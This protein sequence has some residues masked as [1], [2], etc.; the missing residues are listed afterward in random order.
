MGLPSRFVAFGAPNA[1]SGLANANGAPQPNVLEHHQAIHSRAVAAPVPHPGLQLPKRAP[2]AGRA[3]EPSGTHDAR[4]IELPPHCPRANTTRPCGAACARSSSPT[5]AACAAAGTRTGACRTR[6]RPATE[7][8]ARTRAATGRSRWRKASPRTS[9]SPS[10]RRR[11]SASSASIRTA[12][13]ELV[14]LGLGGWGGANRGWVLRSRRFVSRPST[15]VQ[16]RHHPLDIRLQAAADP[17]QRAFHEGLQR[18]VHGGRYAADDA[19]RAR[20]RG[21]AV[22]ARTSSRNSGP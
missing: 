19:R 7:T 2:G 17:V 21:R 12:S 20:G 16:A 9:P 3:R 8:P 13:R 18:Q 5:L 22:Q 15:L 4:T 6:G 10:P 1:S 14:L 11:S